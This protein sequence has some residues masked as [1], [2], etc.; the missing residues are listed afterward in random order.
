MNVLQALIISVVEGITEFLPV[1]ST[2]HMILV[3][4]LLTIAQNEFIKSFEIIIQ[5]GAILAIV[6]LYREKLIKNIMI[7][8]KIF[9][10]F[11]PTGIVGFFLYKFIKNILIGN[12]SIVLLSLFFGGV[13]LIFLDK[14]LKTKTNNIDTLEKLGYRNAFIIGLS[15]SMSI[16]PGVSRS[17]ASIAGA[18]FTG[19]GKDLAVEFSFL[20]AIPTMFGATGLELVKSS[21]SFSTQQYFL[22]AIGF[23]GAFLT[24]VFAV[25]FFLNIIKKCDFMP[26]GVYRIALSLIYWYFI[27]KN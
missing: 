11:I 12:T 13:V 4:N 26:F 6:F 10:A 21:I 8:K 1:S 17:A 15:Q 7:W 23:F 2:G 9:V 18:I 22:L 5:L 3:S 24:A 16:I 25:K 27:V 14:V 19:V 20:L